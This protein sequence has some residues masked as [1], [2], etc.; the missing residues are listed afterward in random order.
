MSESLPNPK[1]QQTAPPAALGPYEPIRPLGM[2][3]MAEVLLAR[4]KLGNGVERTV[5]IKRVLPHIAADPEFVR[6]FATEIRLAQRLK[7]PNIVQVIDAGSEAGSP[8]LVLEALFGADLRAIIRES[9]RRS[10][11]LS[12]ALA[13]AI[14]SQAAKGLH[15]AHTLE[16]ESGAPLGIIHRDVS[17]Q[18]IF[19]TRD[20]SVRVID[21]G[22]AKSAEQIE[23]TRTGV[24]KGKPGYM[25]PEQL[26]GQR[27][28][29]GRV[30]VYALGVVLWELLVGKR[31]W[32]RDSDVASAMAILQETPPKPS[33]IAPRVPSSLDAL[34]LAMLA[35]KPEDRPSME[36][37]ARRLESIARDLGCWSPRTAV[38][39][40]IADLVPER[41]DGFE[42]ATVAT[43][44][45][46][47]ATDDDRAA[48]APNE[49]A[50]TAAHIINA[51]KA[52][53]LLEGAAGSSSESASR[54]AGR[55]NRASKARAPLAVLAALAA[56]GLVAVGVNVAR[57]NQLERSPASLE[58]P[59]ATPA[60]PAQRA[61]IEPPLA[62]A[63]IV[64]APSISPDASAIAA[65]T[66]TAAHP[67]TTTGTRARRRTRAR[68]LS[69]TA[70]FH[71]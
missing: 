18:N 42:S 33:S 71:E 29:D 21:F 52:A 51:D 66:V 30:D 58:A 13:C 17:P 68:G 23:S 2:G 28:I 67:A 36:H 10:T 20:G 22:I 25:S 64:V 45:L 48:P 63:P 9:N 1:P 11:H 24:T 34:A 32:K 61:A 49:G 60:A 14:L 62:R 16:D 7:H 12:P 40:M 39:A 4:Q 8:F 26:R 50:S 41:D 59:A 53:H 19:V 47:A 31:L 43:G 69:S 15:Y 5:V 65:P 35:R 56:A 27:A 57:S 6:L 46:D 54:D 44:S 70:V 3:G 38:A 55:A 37:V